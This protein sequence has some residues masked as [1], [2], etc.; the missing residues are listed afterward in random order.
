MNQLLLNQY[1]SC[2]VVASN[3][4][5]TCFTVPVTNTKSKY[6]I[7][8]IQLNTKRDNR[9]FCL[10]K[11]VHQ[12][13]NILFIKHISFQVETHRAELKLRGTKEYISLPVNIE[14]TSILGLVKCGY[15]GNAHT[16]D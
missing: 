3:F 4:T 12:A 15:H 5:I 8:D 6:C 11:L 2:T 13:S 7:F 16:K 9:R 1:D 14:S 10:L